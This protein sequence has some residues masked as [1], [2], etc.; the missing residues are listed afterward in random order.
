MISKKPHQ[1]VGGVDVSVLQNRKHDKHAQNGEQEIENRSDTAEFQQ[2]RDQNDQLQKNQ[3]H[4]QK[5]AGSQKFQKA[6]SQGFPFKKAAQALGVLPEGGR[7]RLRLKRAVG[8]DGNTVQRDGF[9]RTAAFVT[10][11]LRNGVH[12]V[13]TA[14]HL[15]EHGVL[16]VQIRGA[17]RALVGVGYL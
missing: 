14:V 3:H 2:Q 1:F 10:L 4:E 16:S 7:G 11:H 8:G 9:Q 17:A 13:H 12:N 6:F 5:G 15:T